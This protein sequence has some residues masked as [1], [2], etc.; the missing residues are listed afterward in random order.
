MAISTAW[1][2]WVTKIYQFSENFQSRITYIYLIESISSR[3]IVKNPRFAEIRQLGHVI[4]P[5]EISIRIPRQ[6]FVRRHINLHQ[7]KQNQSKQRK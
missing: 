3:Q 4:Y 6:Q 7:I 1:I 5:S 2:I